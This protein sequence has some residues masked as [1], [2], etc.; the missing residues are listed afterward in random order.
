MW[1]LVGMGY[2]GFGG[3]GVSEV[4]GAVLYLWYTCSGLKYFRALRRT[5]SRWAVRARAAGVMGVRVEGGGCG[6]KGGG[7]R[8]E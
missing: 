3:G 7:C 4:G 2:W 6:V 5:R 1:A 8:V